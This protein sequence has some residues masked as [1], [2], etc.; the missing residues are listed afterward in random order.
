MTNSLS[1]YGDVNIKYYEVN[2]K[3]CEIYKFD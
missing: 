2:D 3:T 1:I